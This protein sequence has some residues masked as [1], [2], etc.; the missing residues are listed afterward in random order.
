[1]IIVTFSASETAELGITPAAAGIVPLL[2]PLVPL[3]LGF[4]A[5]TRAR[6]AWLSR[7]ERGDTALFVALASLMLLAAVELGP[8]GAVRGVTP[9]A[10][11]AHTP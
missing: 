9:A 7:Y 2:A 8:I 6:A 3:A 4:A 11:A 10:R 1:M 5:I